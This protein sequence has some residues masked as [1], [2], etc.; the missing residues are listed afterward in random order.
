MRGIVSDTTPLNYLVLIKAIDVVPRLYKRIL[1]PPAVRAELS[2]PGAPEL[3]QEWIASSPSWL[4]VLPCSKIVDPDLARLDAGEREAILLASELGA[5][6]L[7]MDE[8]DGS[9]VARSRG[10]A[11]IGTLSVLDV[12]ASRGWLDLPEMFDRLNQT[13]FRSPRRVMATM[14]EQNARRKKKDE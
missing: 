7:L 2:A 8:R 14:L 10:L 11:V 6:L 4:E 13:T 1:I 9:A 12:A 5:S 3:V